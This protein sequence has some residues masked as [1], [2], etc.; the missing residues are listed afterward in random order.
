MTPRRL[1]LTVAPGPE[2]R[3]VN[4]LLRRELGLSG[5]LIKRAKQTPGGVLLD[6]EPVFVTARV[7]EGQALSV[8]VGDTRAGEEIRPA[9][10]PLDIV[11]E[12][13]DILILNKPARVAVH[14]GP[15]H[16]GDTIGNFLADYYQ[17]TGQTARFRPVNRLD[18]GTSGLMC[19]AK[20][21]YAHE[22]LKGQ[23]HTPQ[24]RRTYLAVCQGVP[25]PPQGV[26]DAPIGR[27]E[28]SLLKREVR[29]DGAAAC[30][31]YVLVSAAG[32]R[33]LV[34]LVLETGRTHQI[35]VHM[36]H[37]GCPLVGDFLYGREEAALPRRT[38][39][40][41]WELSLR[42][43]VTG[44]ALRWTSPLPEELSALLGE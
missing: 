10:G 30:T 11:Y 7:R 22:K 21:A 37:L 8:Q 17:K 4:D 6:G 40:H 26:V 5:T 43:P 28:G 36:A 12:D 16:D 9:P 24:F 32:G 35:R 2:G 13:E 42:H 1:T 44:Q 3:T 18:R 34:R 20:H 39:L 25:D 41:A 33:S 29:P 31:H 19:V 15:G 23:L 38:A 27:A 14:P